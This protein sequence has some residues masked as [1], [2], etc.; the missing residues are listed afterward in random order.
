MNKVG[1]ILTSIERDELLFKAL[2]SILNNLQENFMVI[3]G[4]QG[5][6]EITFSHPQV[7]IYQLPYDCGISF[8]RNDMI[9]KAHAFGCDYVLLSADSIMFNESMK[10][11]NFVIEQMGKEGYDLCGLNL[12]NR[13][14]WEASLKLIPNQSFE[15]DFIFPWEKEE[16]LLIPCDIVRNFW[17]AKTESLLKVPYD[18]NL[19][20]CEHEDFFYRYKESGFKVCCTNMVNGLYE[21]NENCTPKYNEIRRINFYNGQQ[22]L[23]QKYNLKTWITYQH[24]ERIKQ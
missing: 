2:R 13:I 17:I 8:A 3:V 22:R 20:M 4:Y 11:L 9:E 1:I 21:K 7:Y 15:L 6:K 14:G 5:H 16:Q 24:I 12:M 23:K 18:N 10:N 19:I